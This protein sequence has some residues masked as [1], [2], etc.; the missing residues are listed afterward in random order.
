MNWI[1]KIN[2]DQRY[3]VQLAV[4]VFIATTILWL[5]LRLAAGVNPIWGIAS[6]LTASDPQ[7]KSAAVASRGAIRNTVI[8]CS[9]GLFFVVFGRGLEW[10]VPFAL[11]ATILLSIYVFKVKAMW[12]QAP[13]TA[14]I[15][16]AAN[17]SANA[18]A[19]P[20]E[21]G[22][23]RVM[24]VLFGSFIGLGVSWSMAQ[25]TNWFVGSDDDQCPK[26]F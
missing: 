19:S 3:G 11:T 16:I 4:N 10:S 7:V 25:V 23:K 14:A 9:V 18:E 24:E 22:I 12:Q 5:T 1:R 15:I 2:Q 17:I 13:L 6:M 8:G 20:Y 26:A 21:A